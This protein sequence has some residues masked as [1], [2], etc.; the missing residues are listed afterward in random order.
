MAPPAPAHPF[1]PHPPRTPKRKTEIAQPK[2]ARK[3]VKYEGSWVQGGPGSDD[4]FELLTSPEV[5]RL[6][7]QYEESDYGA[8]LAPSEILSAL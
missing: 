8:E 1:P 2:P 5:R 7:K 4:K 3:M 6:I